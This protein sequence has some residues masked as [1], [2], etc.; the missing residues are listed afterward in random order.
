MKRR[1]PTLHL[2]LFGNRIANEKKRLEALAAE[3]EQ[4]PEREDL[5]K[6][7]RQ[8]HTVNHIDERLS[9]PGLQAPR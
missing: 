8:L 3:R 1:P 7:I 5:L 6:K 2:Y 9:S 4:G